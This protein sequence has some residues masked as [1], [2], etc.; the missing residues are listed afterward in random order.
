MTDRPAAYS[1]ASVPT[2]PGAPLGAG[3]ESAAS[4]LLAVAQIVFIGFVMVFYLGAIPDADRFGT[5]PGTVSDFTDFNRL[6]TAMQS[7]TLLGSGLMI[8]VRWRDIVGLVVRAAPVA[9]I[10]TVML[11]SMTWSDSPEHTL[12][13]SG[14]FITMSLF[15][16]YVAA[17]VGPRRAMR[18]LLA[19]C[20]V[21]ALISLLSIPIDPAFAYDEDNIDSLRGIFGQKNI[22]GEGMMLGTLALSYLV[23][24]RGS[25]RWVDLIPLALF[26][27]LLALSQSATSITLSTTAVMLTLVFLQF[28]R[29]GIW[30]VGGV[31]LCVVVIAGVVA[32][33]GFLQPDDL[34]GSVGKDTT[35][36]GRVFIWQAVQEAIAQRPLLGYGYSAF[37]LTGHAE[38]EAV[39]AE[40]GWLTSSAHNGYLEVF[41]QMGY[42]GLFATAIVAMV[43]M[44][45]A[46]LGLLD[47]VTRPLALWTLLY[48]VVLGVLNYDESAL[49]RP[50]LFMM[51]WVM[52]TVSLARTARA[53]PTTLRMAPPG[54]WPREG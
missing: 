51:L 24:D 21:L 23:L 6:R 29:G 46:V 52:L 28:R 41:L 18:I 47:P 37:W 17:A 20:A 8:M 48:L 38:A 4:R 16:V 22:L 15:A 30:T 27:L 14:S 33:L 31:L 5:D 39:W 25:I 1:T 44:W 43:S 2:W 50:D 26:G 10:A 54:G 11:L 7:I 32:V 19:V 34:A 35:L 9:I 42:P 13:R 53:A 3:N 45:R 40:L 49:L 12:R 36:T